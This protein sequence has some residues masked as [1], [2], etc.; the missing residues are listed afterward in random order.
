MFEQAFCYLITLSFLLLAFRRIL[1]FGQYFQQDE[2]DAKRFMRWWLQGRAF[3]RRVSFVLFILLLLAA[4]APKL[5]TAL[6]PFVFILAAWREPDATKIGKKKLVLTQRA[7]RI[8]GLALLLM[9]PMAAFFSYQSLA[10]ALGAA[11]LGASAFWLSGFL[12]LMQLL[13][14]ALVLANFLLWPFEEMLRQKYIGEAQKKLHALSPRI[15]G[16]AGSFGK[17]S[18]K[19]ILAHLLS[20]QAPTL[21]TPGSVNTILGICRI[22]REKLAAEHQFFIVE[23]GAYSRG[24]V[25]RLCQLFPPQ[26]GIITALGVEHFERFKS[27]DAIVAAELELADA[28]LSKAQQPL[29]LLQRGREFR[30]IEKL[31]QQN[32]AAVCFVGGDAADI[33]EA[34]LTATGVLVQLRWQGEMHTLQAPLYGLVQAENIALAFCMACQLGMPPEHAVLALKSLPQIQHRLEVK[35]T[36]G[37]YTVIDDAYNSNPQGFAA[38]LDVLH[39]LAAAQQGQRI[40]VT[41]GMVELGELHAA[42]HQ[43][44]GAMAALKTDVLLAVCPR[45]IEDF[46]KS[47]EQA[48]GKK[49]VRCPD[50]AAAAAWL[51][52]NAK[53]KDVVLMEND[54]PELYE[55]KIPL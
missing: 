53:E 14:V 9:A 5:A 35:R 23:M 17:T 47:Y 3:D 41:P 42:E 25:A 43:K 29:V 19:H 20:M 31:A 2:Y 13:P 21:A 6:L 10:A 33:L 12:L 34:K 32:I 54:L 4:A 24:S 7:R 52:Q 46:I 18:V 36:L 45:R 40:L 11:A 48:G 8:F 38:A 49:I 15:I 51:Q 16:I 1:S 44:L 28:V 39:Q 50:F 27:L 30:A 55:R 22:I 26:A 37:Q